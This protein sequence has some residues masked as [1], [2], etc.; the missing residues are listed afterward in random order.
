MIDNPEPP[1][2][3]AILADALE[4]F[5][6]IVAVNEVGGRNFVSFRQGVLDGEEGYKARNHAIARRR[7]GSESWTSSDVGSGKILTA[8]VQAITVPGNNLLTIDDRNGPDTRAQFPLEKA[9]G[10]RRTAE[11]EGF[12]LALYAEANTAADANLFS[13]A[14]DLFG[15]NY[16]LIG[17][18]FFLKNIDR[19]TPLRPRGLQAGLT[20]LGIDYPLVQKC[21]WEN[22]AG[23]LRIVHGLRPMLEEA[24]DD[25]RLRLI[26]AH[27]FLWVLG[28]WSRGNRAEGTSKNGPISSYGPAEMAAYEIAG[29]IL[30][31]VSGANG[32]IVERRVKPKST[33]MG[34]QE[35]EAHVAELIHA[36]KGLC[37][38]TGLP[39]DLPPAI[40]DSDMKAS[41][42][43]I[44]S[45]LGYEK[46]NIQVVCWFANR[47]KGDDSDANFRRLL[48]RFGA[49]PAH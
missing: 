30:S 31:T 6:E 3:H 47:W 17:Y 13:V 37:A 43:R 2:S 4:L 49:G 41:P 45:D 39:L 5:R 15:R 22:Y 40:A 48:S 27:S 20:E 19:F 36:Q 29:N 38:L 25:P 23:F 8:M 42:D 18:F 32:Q 34:R 26:D 10:E 16:P 28:S 1:V 21:S 33:S 7:M 35:L 14:V 24:L 11:M 46:G 9:L 44:D 12:F